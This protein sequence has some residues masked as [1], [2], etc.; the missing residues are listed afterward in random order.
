MKHWFAIIALI[1]STT[2]F[3]EDST[4]L[5]DV[6]DSLSQTWQSK[7]Y[8]LYIPVNT[9]HNRSYYTDEKIASYEEI[10]EIKKLLKLCQNKY[11]LVSKIWI[12]KLI[13]LFS[14]KKSI[15]CRFNYAEEQFR[16]RIISRAAQIIW[17]N[18][19]LNADNL[20]GA[21]TGKDSDAFRECKIDL[22]EQ[23]LFELARVAFEAFRS[24]FGCF[25]P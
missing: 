5:S 17:I 14:I 25:Q 9:W 10:D 7:D 22:D 21:Q 19:K 4:I 3:A 1:A 20:N 11:T 6:Q 23:T 16:I 8:E 24:K 18:S 12:I 15:I 13:R 2:S